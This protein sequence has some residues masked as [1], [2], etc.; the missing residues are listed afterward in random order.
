M[1]DQTHDRDTLETRE[2]LEALD[3]IMFGLPS[4]NHLE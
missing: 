3:T 1:A 4:C 2:W